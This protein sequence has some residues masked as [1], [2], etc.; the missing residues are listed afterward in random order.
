MPDSAAPIRI[1]LIDDHA[2][3]R[4]SVGRLLGSE[5]GFRVVGGCASVDAGLAL[6]RQE[7]V[8]IVLLDFD[9]GGVTEHNSC[10]RPDSAALGDKSSL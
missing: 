5:P 3:F 10:T 8:D 4:E 9:L 7:H 6:L 2:L 1:L